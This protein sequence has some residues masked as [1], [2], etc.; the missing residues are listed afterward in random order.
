MRLP[1]LLE[2]FVADFRNENRTIAWTYLLSAFLFLIYIF[3]AK[4]VFL[5]G[6]GFGIPDQLSG[7][8]VEKQLRKTI[9]GLFKQ[10]D[11][12]RRRY[13]RAQG[14]RK[15][16]LKQRMGQVNGTLKQEQK[17]L[18]ALNKNAHQRQQVRTFYRYMGWF[19]GCF[20]VLFLVPVLVVRLFL[21]RGSPARFGLALGDMHYGIRIAAL[22]SVVMVAAVLVLVLTRSS[23]FLRYYPM[24]VPRS[25]RSSIPGFLGWFMVMEFAY[26]LYFVGWE[27]FF[28]GLLIFPLQE[29][30]GYMAAVVGIL[31]FAIMHIGKPVPEA[32]GSVVAAYLLGVLALRARS[33]WVCPVIHFVVAFSM[34]LAAALER[35]LF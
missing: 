17:K 26:L 2:P 29:R 32:F 21:P 31:P 33:F 19:L 35:G 16:E 3:F 27:Y 8:G 28:R 30:L 11:E 23:A 6:D 15:A 1:G 7:M 5:K 9:R 10:Q 20:V 18:R 34:D 4:N 24:Y 12:L 14:T 22:F 25:V 13:H